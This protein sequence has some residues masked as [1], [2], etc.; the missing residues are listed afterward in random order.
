[1]PRLAPARQLKILDFDIE[2]RP[3]SYLG[4][5]FTTAEI[6]SIAASFYGEDTIYTWLL[7]IDQMEDILQG[8]RVLYDDADIVT[9]HYIR[10]HDLP[11]ITDMLFEAGLPD[12][13]PKLTSD[14]KVDLIA[15]KG[16]SKSQENLSAML[17]LAAPKV[18]MNTPRWRA[19]N[20]LTPEGIALTRERVEGDII[21]HKQLRQAL[22]EQRRLRPPVLWKP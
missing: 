14:T 8:F 1:M 20:R 11:I 7:G 4:M 21:Q 2:N 19:A 22:V 5:D 17:E 6:T 3:L 15:G 12:L 13:G 18:Q 16:I 9:G 10:R